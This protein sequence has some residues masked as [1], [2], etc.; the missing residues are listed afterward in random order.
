MK[1]FMISMIAIFS[2]GCD[3]PKSEEVLYFE[4]IRDSI[5]KEVLKTDSE[6]IQAETNLGYDADSISRKYK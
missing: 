4:H 6:L 5:H 1:Q 3:Q 2:F